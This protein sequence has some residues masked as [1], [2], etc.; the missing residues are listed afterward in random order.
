LLFDILFKELLIHYNNIFHKV[1][2]AFF[3]SIS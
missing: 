1:K 3:N 2:I